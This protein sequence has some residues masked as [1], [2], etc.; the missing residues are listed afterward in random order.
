MRHGACGFRMDV[1]NMISKDQRFP[2]VEPTVDLS[3][4]FQPGQEHLVNGPRLHEYLREMNREVLSKYNSITVGELSCV[5]DVDEILWTVG[6][7]AGELNMIFIF[8][9][10]DIDRQNV[11]MELKPWDVYEFRRIVSK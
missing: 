7:K 4:K 11:K 2:D 3:H 9:L 6:S 5:S 10:V 1:I 8:D